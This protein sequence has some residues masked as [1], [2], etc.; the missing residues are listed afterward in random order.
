[1]MGVEEIILSVLFALGGNG[2]VDDAQAKCMA[3]NLYHEARSE[4]VQ[5]MVQVAQVVLER[6][7][8]KRYPS[9]PCGVIYSANRENGGVPLLNKCAFSWVCDGK[10][11]DVSGLQVGNIDYSAYVISSIVAVGTM[12]GNYTDK[13]EKSNFY[14]NPTL[15]S[16]KWARHYE[17]KCKIGNHVFMLRERGNLF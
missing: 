4:P 3:T 10:Y 6:A 7:K 5:G 12:M 13:C 11:D 9:T 1:M 8:D 16:P 15:A 17:F 14:Y 2:I